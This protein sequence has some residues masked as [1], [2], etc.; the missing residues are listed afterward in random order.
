MKN[1]QCDT[2]IGPPKCAVTLN[3]SKLWPNYYIQATTIVTNSQVITKL[4]VTSCKKLIP[5][6][7][8]KLIPTSYGKAN[9]DDLWKAC[10][11]ELY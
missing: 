11:N 9:L 10:S 7:V 4:Q 3:K 2:I 1:C 6:V 8:K 5:K